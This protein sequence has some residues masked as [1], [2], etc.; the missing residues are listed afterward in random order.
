MLLA[1]AGDGP[2]IAALFRVA[3]SHAL[4]QWEADVGKAIGGDL[5]LGNVIVT[6]A[7]KENAVVADQD[8]RVTTR[9]IRDFLLADF[10][11]RLFRGT[12]AHLADIDPSISDCQWLP[13]TDDGPKV[14]REARQ[15]REGQEREQTNVGH[16]YIL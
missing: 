13:F 9:S 6:P 3:P 4:A 14:L 16:P 8:V 11:S 15:Q 2:E 12:G 7:G 1:E 5:G 10:D